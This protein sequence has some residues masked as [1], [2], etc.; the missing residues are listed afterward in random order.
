MK[1]RDFVYID[2]DKLYSLYSQTFEGIAEKVVQSYIDRLTS[3]DFQKGA[4][5]GGA[6]IEKQAEELSSRTESRVLHDH[7]V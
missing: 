4:P 7:N 5:L 1:I 2:I 3:K 6:S